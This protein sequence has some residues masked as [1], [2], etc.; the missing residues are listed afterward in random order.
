MVRSDEP[1]LPSTVLVMHMMHHKDPVHRESSQSSDFIG[2]L[3]LDETDYGNSLMTD[4]AQLYLKDFISFKIIRYVG[5][6]LFLGSFLSDIITR[7]H[8]HKRFSHS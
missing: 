7:Q 3:V 6:L 8:N 2:Q 4:L 5:G 1:L